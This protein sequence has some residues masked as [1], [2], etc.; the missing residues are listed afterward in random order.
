MK[1]RPTPAQE[2]SANPNPTRVLVADDS[3][4]ARLHLR[5]LLGSNNFEVVAEAPGAAQAVALYAE[6][7]P[8]VVT[9]D[10][11]MPGL[12]GLDAVLAL[13]DLNPR[14]RIVLITAV[15]EDPIVQGLLEMGIPVVHKP[16]RW[17]ELE[18][19]LSEASSA[20]SPAQS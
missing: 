18:T 16:V 20:G 8:D 17:G 2:R 9:M 14:C 19:A 3:A 1:A 11:N 15:R 5:E 10:L 13:R 7:Q 4:F 6:L 12:S